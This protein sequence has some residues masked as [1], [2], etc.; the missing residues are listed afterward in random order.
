VVNGLTVQQL[1]LSRA[2]VHVYIGTE[3]NLIV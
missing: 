1:C 2:A 3:V